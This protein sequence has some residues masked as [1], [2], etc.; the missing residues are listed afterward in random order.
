MTSKLLFT[1]SILLVFQFAICQNQN[2]QAAIETFS[3]NPSL[4]SA[5]IS[6]L[7]INSK[8]KSV[9]ASFDP[10]RCLVPASTTKLWST[11]ASLEIL[12]TNYAPKTE[13]LYTGEITEAGVL[14]GDIIIK[15]YG[16]ATI[17]SEHFATRE[18]MRDFFKDWVANLTAKNIK[19]IEG[20]VFADASTLGYFGTPEGWTWSDMGNY[21]GA[22]PSGLTIYD[23]M[24]E[25]YFNTSS[26]KNE[27]TKISRT[28]PIIENFK[29]YNYV[30]SDAVQSDNAYVFAAPYASEGFVTGTLPLNK[31][32]FRVKASV[33]NPEVLFAREFYDAILNAGIQITGKPLSNKMLTDLNNSTKLDS[34]NQ[35][36]KTLLFTHFGYSITEIIKVINQKSNNLFAEHLIHWIALNKDQNKG[37]HKLGMEILVKHWT[38][39]FDMQ[40]A[41][42]T[43]GSGL[44]RSNSISAQH[45]TELL[46]YMKDNAVFESTLPIS[47]QSGTLKNLCSGQACSGKIKA[48][49]GT[50][51]G[52]KAYAGYAYNKKGEKIIF[53]FIVNNHLGSSSEVT[54]LM[55]SVLN[56]LVA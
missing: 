46:Y 51:N 37:Y 29:L 20:D 45:F 6:F 47:G 27:T 13:V 55:E 7:A 14:K 8:D 41:R 40:T 42:I 22:F 11:A 50:I 21:Y 23:N 53:A 25:L 48:K 54:K 44:S 43:D 9:V 5:S 34:L 1:T 26:R 28:H 35:S 32:D 33:Q 12:S 16:D 17:G 10:N 2:I 36:K 39:K 49:S 30:L 15:G 31:T 18:T 24:L 38:S 19:V 4:R 56:A 3:K 52:V